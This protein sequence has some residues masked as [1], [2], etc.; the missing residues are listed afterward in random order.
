MVDV[1]KAQ[2][3]RQQREGFQNYLEQRAAAL[4]DA[5]TESEQ[6]G[7]EAA[8]LAQPPPVDPAAN[9]WRNQEIEAMGRLSLPLEATQHANRGR[10]DVNTVQ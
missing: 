9:R 7:W 4:V 1:I 8:V 10:F 6:R 2:T 3:E 5:T